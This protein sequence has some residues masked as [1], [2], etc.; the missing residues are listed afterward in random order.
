MSLLG[1]SLSTEGKK[2]KPKQATD[3][4]EDELLDA[5]RETCTL[6]G[7][8]SAYFK[9]QLYFCI[10]DEEAVPGHNTSKMDVHE[11][12]QVLL[13]VI[14]AKNKFLMKTKANRKISSES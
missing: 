14:K 2:K 1:L 10:L 9:F 13:K 3:Y 8:N 7:Q 5:F 11:A 12:Y 6:I 4:S